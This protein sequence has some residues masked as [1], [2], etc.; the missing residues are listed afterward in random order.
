MSTSFS[1]A[2]NFL[3]D[4]G[5]CAYKIGSGECDNYPLVKHIASFGKP[6]IMSTGMNSIESARAS[7]EI[8]KNAGCDLALLQC[9]PISISPRDCIAKRDK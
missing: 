3:E 7:V 1:R 8:I 2:A 6:I 4:I 9:Q 5:A